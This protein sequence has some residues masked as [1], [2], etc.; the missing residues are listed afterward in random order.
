MHLWGNSL[1]VQWLGLSA[2]TAGAWVQSLVGELRHHKLCSTA[3]AKK[4]FTC[5]FGTKMTLVY[6]TIKLTTLISLD[7]II[8]ELCNHLNIL[9]FFFN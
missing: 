9:N 7:A 1:A 2:F 6:T 3:P 4:K 5:A 8:D